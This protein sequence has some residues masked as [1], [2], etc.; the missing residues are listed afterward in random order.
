MIN[1]FLKLCEEIGVP[2]SMDKTEWSSIRMVFLGILLDGE[3]LS[4]A[5]PIKK[6]D[7][8]VNLLLEF[9]QKKKVTVKDLQKLCG[10]LNFLCKAIFPGQTFT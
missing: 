1:Q 6:K 7:F 10:Y 2:V 4:L 8:A 5:V 3:S 9:Q